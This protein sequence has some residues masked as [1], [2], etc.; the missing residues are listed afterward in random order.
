MKDVRRDDMRQAS[1][2]SFVVA[3][4]ATLRSRLMGDKVRSDL[5]GLGDGERQAIELAYFVGRTYRGIAAALGQPEGTIK[6]RIRS[7]LVRLRQGLIEAGIE[8]A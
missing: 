6:S 1:D 3:I 7:G 5:R 8:P 2:A 4:G